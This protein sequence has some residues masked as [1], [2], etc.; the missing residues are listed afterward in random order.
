M[1]FSHPWHVLGS[2]KFMA[3]WKW[4]IDWLLC[5]NMAWWPIGQCSPSLN[6]RTVMWGQH[7]LHFLTVHDL[8][9]HYICYM[10]LLKLK[11]FQCQTLTLQLNFQSL[12]CCGFDSPV[13][14][15]TC[16]E[17]CWLSFVPELWLGDH[18]SACLQG[19]IWQWIP[20]QHLWVK[21]RWPKSGQSSVAWFRAH[22]QLSSFWQEVGDDFSVGYLFMIRSATCSTT[23]VECT[24]KL[25]TTAW[26]AMNKGEHYIFHSHDCYCLV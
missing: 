21:T 22:F 10:C 4:N 26:L 20:S 18:A 17:S 19:L 8:D 24:V 15:R 13:W 6:L 9:F 25:F 12:V 2:V 1:I 16:H 23:L 5:W 3:K 7:R 11:T 14:V